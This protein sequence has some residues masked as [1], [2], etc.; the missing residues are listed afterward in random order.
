MDLPI[1]GYFSLLQTY[2]LV[3]VIFSKFG[4]DTASLKLK[5]E[6]KALN[7]HRKLYNDYHLILKIIIVISSF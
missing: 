6:N 4:L 3:V 2:L 1:L 7:R 5:S